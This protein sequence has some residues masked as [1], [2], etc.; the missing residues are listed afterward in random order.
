M[1]NIPTIIDIEC[2]GATNG[3]KGNPFSVPNRA[4]LIGIREKSVNT[5][6]NQPSFSDCESL[7]KNKFLVGFNIKFDLH[8][9]SR[10]VKLE[11]KH[12]WD[13]QYA[14]Y[15]IQRQQV[16]YI[17]LD[18]C[19]VKY[20]YPLKLDIVASE[21]W[22][23]GLDTDEVPYDILKEYLEGDLQRTQW[24]Y[25]A[26]LNY[27][28]DKPDLYRLICLGNN[29]LINTYY[30]EQSGIV[31]DQTSSIIEGNRLLDRI[32]EIDSILDSHLPNSTRVNWNSNDHISA[33][34]YGGVIKE[35]YRESYEQ[36]LKSGIVK[37]KERWSIREV[38]LPALVSPLKGTEVLKQGYYQVNE[39]TLIKLRNKAT[40]KAKQIVDLLLE[41]AK[42]EK[43]V[44]SYYH[45]LPKLIET[46]KWPDNVIHGQ[47]NH[48]ITRTGRIA[49][50]SPNQQNF[51][52]EIGKFCTSRY[53]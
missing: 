34:L 5:I 21:Y 30:M 12:I 35:R 31:Y 15:C 22:N 28:A 50:K 19:L 8:W 18:D 47:L 3:T 51:P 49:S 13:C 25:E 33:V 53:T 42:L 38:E 7:L 6:L 44:S 11:P 2:T 4:V 27:L 29:D 37:Q 40:K 16:P 32:T 24:V 23:K 46:M 14:E 1:K 20:G 41:R 45:G 48:A 9:I 36:T 43:A 17:S 39:D 52:E 10:Y 26:Q